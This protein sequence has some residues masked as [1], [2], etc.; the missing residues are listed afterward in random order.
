MCF[1]E[2]YSHPE[3]KLTDHLSNVSD[4][5][6]EK[7]NST[8]HNLRF[9]VPND[10]LKR[11]I[12][13]SGFAH[14]LGKSTKYFQDYLFEEDEKA[15]LK[16][17]NKPETNHSFISAL[18]TYI[19]AKEFSKSVVSNN[20]LISTM[21]FYLFLVVKKHHGNLKNAVPFKGEDAEVVISHYQKD[22]VENQIKGIDKNGFEKLVKILSE[23][24]S[25]NIDVENLLNLRNCKSSIISIER[26]EKRSFKKLNKKLDHYI[27]FQFIYSIL[28]H[29]DKE[30]AIFGKNPLP[31]RFE[32]NSNVVKTFKH[33]NFGK[34]ETL[35]N[36]VREEIFLEA[37]ESIKSI[38]L[39]KKILSLNVPTGSGK[40]FT[41][42][43]C[44]LELRERI[45]NKIGYIPRIIYSLPFTSIIDQN[46]A[47]FEEILE[48]PET[49]TLLKH[50]HLADISYRSEISDFETSESKFLVESWESEIVVTTFFQ[51]FH[52]L[53]TNRNRMVQKFHKFAGSI[54]LIDEVQAIPVKYW[55]L[56]K[57][58]LQKTSK[59]LNT[60]FI[61]ITATQPAI[62]K[63]G[64][65]CELVKNKENYF[66][67]M[68]RV[69]ISFEKESLNL[70]A[71][72]ELCV[73]TV[74]ES[75]ESFLFVMNTINSSIELFK[76]LE[77]LELN[78]DY[79]YLAT[80]IIPKERLQRI[81]NIKKSKN[82]RIIVSTQMIEAG[83]DIDVENVW[84]DFGP[85]E[86][87][88]QVCGRCNR[89]NGEKR[90]KVKIF[91]ILNENN[92]N[93]PYSDYIYGEFPVAISETKKILEK[94]SQ[95]PESK[96]LEN[97][98]EYYKAISIKMS[99]QNSQDLITS[100][101]QLKFQEINDG[102]KLIDEQEYDRTDVF[103][104]IDIN[105]EKV[106]Q[107]YLEIRE[108]QS[109]FDRKNEFLKIKQKFND[110][111]ISVPSKFV[112][113]ERV[114]NS[115]VVYVS[116][117]KVTKLYDEKTGWIREVPGIY[118]I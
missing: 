95:I 42:L 88:N 101:K 117:E 69:D 58:M 35:I 26:D 115:H 104:E 5:C 72:K 105:A 27:L 19:I 56:V 70:S 13:I 66:K 118:I 23:N 24:I 74:V 47:V 113:Y 22:A 50:H 43:S 93:K 45:K 52:T 85:L 49:S 18:F 61:L 86:S 82:K 3:K 111:V 94:E 97:I 73:K 11:F 68:D 12:Y 15:K 96:F 60:Y 38:N 44:A 21:P 110:Y 31:E 100:L 114:E 63:S 53:F 102:F 54:V 17:K 64:E 7:L 34:P 84:R 16:M 91:K 41:S 83:V 10:I 81:K 107:T 30:D 62:F 76:E 87:I 77:K 80:N 46:Y 33:K 79:Y 8:H 39:D 1:S 25:F 51:I 48:F 14:D 108:I 106:W 65:F 37:D 6:V 75:E 36:K 89:N 112:F 99:Q 29:S 9:L 40:T 90:G 78:A 67:E 32:L 116:K 59:L 109:L 57:E 103:V 4:R 20:D 71:F 2:L 55:E 98:S 92:N 28:L